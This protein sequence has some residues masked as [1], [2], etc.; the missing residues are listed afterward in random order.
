MVEP[1]LQD[2]CEQVAILDRLLEDEVDE[3][4]VDRVVI[5][6]RD[7]LILLGERGFEV[8]RAG[9]LDDSALCAVAEELANIEE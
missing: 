4:P 1:E 6:R 2:L 7:S 3:E 9:K 5:Q 8:L